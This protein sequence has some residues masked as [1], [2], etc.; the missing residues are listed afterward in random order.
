MGGV[1]GPLGLPASGETY[2]PGGGARSDF[3][4]GLSL[5][6]GPTTGARALGS[7]IVARWTAL[8]AGVSPIGFPTD[9]ERWVAGG[10]SASFQNGG[11]YWSS[12]TG[13]Q[14][15]RA[16]I[17][18]HYR[19]SGGPADIGF[20]LYPEQPTG[21]ALYQQF[22]RLSSIYWSSYTGAH[23]VVGGIRDHWRALGAEWGPL[24]LPTGD[25]TAVAGGRKSDFQGGTV[26]WSPSSGAHAVLSAI[27]AGYAAQGGPSSTLGFPVSDQY[28]AGGNIRQDFSGGS[29]IWYAASNSVLRAT[30]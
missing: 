23:V 11:I 4:S 29:L 22:S 7:G 5:I 25:E 1:S 9:D 27:G 17:D 2:L 16:A 10:S 21:G 6:W 28:A 12:T 3:S 26:Y 13:T 30:P 24:G 14:P 15:V 18:Q 19:A 8:G 20:P